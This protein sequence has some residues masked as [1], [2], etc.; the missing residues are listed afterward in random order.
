MRSALLCHLRPDVAHL[1]LD[2]KLE[3]ACA[4]IAQNCETTKRVARA[5]ADMKNFR[6]QGAT[7][8]LV[9][10]AVVLIVAL[11]SVALLGFFPG[12][13]QDAQ[14]TQSKIYWSSASPIAVVEASAAAYTPAPVYTE[15][16]IRIRNVGNY[17]I[18]I[19]KI[20]ERNGG[21]ISKFY[22]A[23][24]SSDM[25]IT[26]YYYLAPGEEKYFG[27]KS[28]FPGLPEDREVAIKAAPGSSGHII[29]S[30]SSIC[31]IGANTGTLILD[32]FGFEYIQYMEGQ[33]LTKRQVGVK[34]LIIKCSG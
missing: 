31:T 32:D 3:R 4:E 28:Y 29:G 27:K 2:G 21:Y 12:M 11:V 24:V 17:P 23:N 30:A 22:D 8:Y 1:L 20:L 14:M 25:N 16:Y 9:L 5:V 34:P 10:L 26:D 13:S 6:A 18:R 19:S 15:M 7:E 33:Q